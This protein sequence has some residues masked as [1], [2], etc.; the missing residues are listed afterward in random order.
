MQAAGQVVAESVVRGIEAVLDE[1]DVADDAVSPLL[2]DE[3]HC[4]GRLGVPETGPEVVHERLEL[5]FAAECRVA[6]SGIGVV[7]VGD[8]AVEIGVVALRP[9]EPARRELVRVAALVGVVV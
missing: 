3:Q 4:V 2:A 8:A 9:E 7:P 1:A 6:L 5:A